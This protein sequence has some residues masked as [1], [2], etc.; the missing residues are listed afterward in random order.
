MF[1]MEENNENW[2]KYSYMEKNLNDPQ[3]NRVIS[4]PRFSQL[5]ES[6]YK[7]KAFLN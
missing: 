2:Q 3:N 1:L 5:L 4:E 7:S 6:L